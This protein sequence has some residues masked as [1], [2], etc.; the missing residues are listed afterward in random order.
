LILQDE[1]PTNSLSITS[2]SSDIANALNAAASQMSN[3]ECRSFGVSAKV[4]N[5]QQN[6]IIKVEFYVDNVNPLTLL[7]VY[8][9]GLVGERF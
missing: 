8:S 6:V 5:N 1:Q 7:S 4:T 3:A 2:T 9:G